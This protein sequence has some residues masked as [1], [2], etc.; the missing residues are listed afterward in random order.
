ML[1]KAQKQIDDKE[2]E[3]QNLEIELAEIEKVLSA[4]GDIEQ[5]IF[6]KYSDVQKQLETAMSY[7]ELACQ[8]YEELKNK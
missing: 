5:S 1:R 3:I 8:E 4:G 6:Q 7:W 2:T